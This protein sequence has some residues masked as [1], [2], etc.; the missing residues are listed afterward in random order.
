MTF[1]AQATGGSDSYEYCFRIRNAVNGQ[2]SIAQEYS[3]LAN[4][5][6]NATDTIDYIGVLARNAGSKVDYQAYNS[7]SFSTDMY[8]P[9]SV[10]LRSDLPSP[11][12]EGTTV[13]FTAQTNGGSGSYEYRFWIRNAVNGQWS[14]AQDYS[15]LTNYTWNAK[16][17]VD[18]IGVWARNAGSKARYQVKDSIKFSTDMYSLTSVSLSSVL[19]SPQPEGTA[20][21]FTAQAALRH[22]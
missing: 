12:P 6:W 19:P 3:S 1:T 18:R 7:I 20:M 22:H 13:A 15:S 9:T 14:I 11:Q 2:W 17:T 8:S 4:Y 10:S 16:D 21:T 5:I